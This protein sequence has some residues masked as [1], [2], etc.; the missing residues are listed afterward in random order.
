MIPHLLT[1]LKIMIGF[2]IVILVLSG[3]LLAGLWVLSPGKPQHLTDKNGKIIPGS[4]SEKIRV[5]IGGISQGIF[6]R[7]RDTTLPVLLYVHG[8][9]AFPNYFLIEKEN[10]RL[11]DFFT[12][13][14][15]EQRGGGLSYQADMD[16]ASIT[17]D[18]LTEDALEVTQY[19]RNRFHQ[20]KI[21]I[22]AHSGG[23]PIALKAVQ[24]MPGWFQAYI[25]MAQVTH[26]IKSEREAFRW[27]VDSL[28]AA[29]NQEAVARLKAFSVMDSDQALVSFFRS[30]DRDKTMHEL[31]VGTMHRMKSIFFDIFVPVWT[32]R[33]YTLG[34]KWDI[35]KSK[36]TFLP[37][38]PLTETLILT[39]FAG[40][41]PELQ[42]PVYLISGKYDKTVSYDLS[43]AYLQKLKAPLKGFYTFPESAH[44][45][46]F[47]EPARF[48]KILKEDVLT[49]QC[50]LAD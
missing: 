25:G 15:W 34:E 48:R 7:S 23:T 12:V 21:Y 5:P 17:F 30:V 27:M 46:L 31:G 38:T 41:V 49:G 13:C 39:D 16:P 2:H 6:I 10:P 14:Y 24:K 18:R 42:V 8:G 28:E 45:P 9:P 1:G 50:R 22:L 43:K 29:G 4:F 3:V 44:S 33:G 40:Q 20:E 37:K 19:L 35:W 11:E 36:F 47:E 32:C 26:Q